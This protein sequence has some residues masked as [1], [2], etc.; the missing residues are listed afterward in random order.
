MF[1]RIANLFKG[2]LS[3]FVSG[4]ERRNPEALLVA[5]QKGLV[6]MKKFGTVKPRPAPVP[7]RKAARLGRVSIHADAVARRVAERYMGK[8]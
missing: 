1:G 3:L 5:V 7:A 8:I 4:I 2:F 6:P